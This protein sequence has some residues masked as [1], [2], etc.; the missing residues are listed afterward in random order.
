MVHVGV[1]GGEPA[2]GQLQGMRCVELVSH[3]EEERAL[4][5]RDVLI[6]RMKM[7]R[8]LVAVGQVQPYR[9]RRRFAWVSL[10]HGH[11]CAG[12]YSRWSWFPFNGC[13][14]IKMHLGR[15]R[16]FGR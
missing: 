12:R 16:L 6:G 1:H 10:K 15:W 3:A 14:R 2:G 5:D 9:E 11:F 13:R 8:H 4:D 7:R